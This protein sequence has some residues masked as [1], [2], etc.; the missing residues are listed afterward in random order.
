M[1]RA[2]VIGI[3]VSITCLSII[4]NYQEIIIS[5]TAAM[6]EESPMERL[7]P[8]LKPRCMWYTGN[9]GESTHCVFR[10]ACYSDGV[11]YIK[12]S[13]EMFPKTRIFVSSRMIERIYIP[14][15]YVSDSQPLPVPQ[16][17]THIGGISVIFHPLFA[18]DYGNFLL[19]NWYPLVQLLEMFGIQSSRFSIFT[20]TPVQS[21][22]FQLFANLHPGT[23]LQFQD[24]RKTENYVY[25]ATNVTESMTCFETLVVG[26][27]RLS[28]L[29]PN[30]AHPGN[31]TKVVLPIAQHV[32]DF[33]GQIFRNY[34][35]RHFSLPNTKASIEPIDIY[36]VIGNSSGR[37]W[38]DLQ[39]VKEDVLERVQ[40]YLGDYFK[41]RNGTAPEIRMFE[42]DFTTM[43]VLDQIRL[44]RNMS[45]FIGISGPAM[46]NAIFLPERSV[47]IEI[48]PAVHQFENYGLCLRDAVI[49]CQVYEAFNWYL[50]A[51]Q[52]YG[53]WNNTMLVHDNLEVV[54]ETRNITK[55]VLCSVFYLLGYYEPFGNIDGWK[56]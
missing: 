56:H 6:W 32:P 46:Y 23:M 33:G 40:I 45:V 19:D 55:N 51:K 43:S 12:D 2:K 15:V 22:L 39:T 48:V 20:D 9:G 24:A 41:R 8:S 13:L 34:V 47:V 10:G 11:L 17:K 42:I 37:V 14:I 1:A 5:T 35:S 4:L 38:H 29:W 28:P 3:L 50:P 36:F 16:K 54:V 21:D 44:I 31:A 7:H 25:N 52:E 26:L 53:K 27:D 30:G 18:S 49:Y